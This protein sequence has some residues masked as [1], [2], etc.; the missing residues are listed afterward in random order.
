MKFLKRIVLVVCLLCA[1]CYG[2]LALITGY[3]IILDLSPNIQSSTENYIKG[4]S[5]NPLNNFNFNSGKWEAYLLLSNDDY[6]LIKG[7]LCSNKLFT[8]DISILNILKKRCKFIYTGGDLSTVTS[9]F[10]LYKNGTRVFETGV[11]IEKSLQGFQN[12]NYGWITSK[13][14][15]INI[16]NRF[17]KLR[18]PFTILR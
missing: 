2:G 6:E 8:D 10:I 4:Q 13:Y 17:D 11:V 3:P 9:S 1:V 12:Q 7:D 5:I 15:L 14:N 16:F 18:S